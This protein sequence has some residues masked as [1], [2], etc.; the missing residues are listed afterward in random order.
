MRIVTEMKTGRLDE[1]IITIVSDKV[2]IIGIVGGGGGGQVWTGLD[3]GGH[4]SRVHVISRDTQNKR[5][6]I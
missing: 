2:F 1:K 6:I 3:T 4:V 5:P